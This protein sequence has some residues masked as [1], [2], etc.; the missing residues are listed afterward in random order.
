MISRPTLI[1]SVSAVV[2]T[3]CLVGLL[4]TGTTATAPTAAA[5]PSTAEW[6]P[7][8]A[9][10]TDS[11]KTVRWDN[12]DNPAESVV[13]RDATQVIPFTGG[14]TYEDIAAPIK[15]GWRDL[16]SNLTMTVGQTDNVTG[17]GVSVSVTG[18]PPIVDENGAA[19][20]NGS[21]LML[22][23][24][25]G[26]PGP[27]GKPSPDAT[28]PDPRTCQEG[29]GGSDLDN[30]EAWSNRLFDGDAL[31]RSSDFKD[32]RGMPWLAIDGTETDAVDG[33]GTILSR[34]TTNEQSRLQ[35]SSSLGAV[36]RSF[37]MQTGTESTFLGCGMRNDAPSTSNCW[38][39]A[40]PYRVGTSLGAHPSGLTP[41][42]WGQRMQV[43]IG[44]ADAAGVCASSDSRVLSAGSEL[45]SPA[46]AS[47]IPG[48]CSTAGVST[49]YSQLSDDQARRSLDSGASPLILSS[50][51]TKNDATYVPTALSGVTIGFNYENR[52]ATD[53]CDRGAV[54][55]DIRLNA[56][57][58][59]KLLTQSYGFDTAGSL[60]ASKAPWAQSS[61][62]DSL[63]SDPEF[64]AL[65]PQLKG[66]LGS[67]G[68][69]GIRKLE[70]ETL[71]SDA[72]AALWDWVVADRDAHAFLN[73]CADPNGL[74]V[75]PWYST[76]TYAEC[77]GD[78]ATLEKAAAEKRNATKTPESFD[79]DTPPSYPP[80][81]SSYPQILYASSDPIGTP[82]STTP[83]TPAPG[84]PP[85][86][87]EYVAGATMVDIYPSVA[88]S[89]A[90]A[91]NGLRAAPTR[92]KW[93]DGN[94]GGCVPALW[95]AGAAPQVYGSRNIAVATDTASAARYQLVT[96]SLCTSDGN[97]CVGANEDSLTK[98]FGRYTSTGITSPLKAPAAP[99]Y[100][101]GAY[102]LAVPVYGVVAQRSLTP[103]SGRTFAKIFG[104]ITGP[105]QQPGSARGQLPPGFAP[106]SGD[107]ASQ[108]TTAVSALNSVVAPAAAAPGGAASAGVQPGVANAAPTGV[109]PRT[110]VPPVAA[111]SAPNADAAAN[112]AN[113][114]APLAGA[115]T[116]ATE[117]GFPQYG[118]IA[119][120]AGAL[121]AGIFAPWLGR[122]RKE[123]AE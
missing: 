51:P 57:L 110:V 76:R 71:K 14:K 85:T 88:D 83:S 95:K 5:A 112:A 104:Y 23:Q 46:M 31:A 105:G 82:P 98:Q 109:V 49:G 77:A 39:V 17:Q 120:L 56:R 119:G 41:S 20:N 48:L 42:M 12:R 67:Y 3:L 38:L 97:S 113:T 96:A 11:Q 35:T 78:K 55:T 9:T 65:N 54:L 107:F 114:P 10:V 1:R 111:A 2:G 72:A 34:I 50:R 121:A 69:D 59:A 108:A 64:L 26:A 22:F 37:E 19:I 91:R 81:Q 7:Q 16:F 87:S 63:S 92:G 21:A 29:P 8:G 40:V 117:I 62:N 70:T 53:G 18:L 103:D 94:T 116:A 66:T 25:W 47:W 27:D 43:K 122:R 58:V 80:T 106:L 45:A 99:D 13:P 32:R 115:K 24:C 52:C 93:C 33:S 79:R 60:L 90:A 28:S 73:G 102:P 75:N 74:T 86:P 89:A 68:N 36:N 4:A 61:L 15:T 101:G 30:G 44:F 123:L 6:G 100:A 84:T 118:L